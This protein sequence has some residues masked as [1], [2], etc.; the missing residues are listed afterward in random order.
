MGKKYEI[1]MTS[2]PIFSKIL[3]FALPLML[4]SMLQLLF[5]TADVI[6]VGRFCGASSLAA[7]GSTGSLTNL[8]VNLF[9]GFSVGTNVIAAQAV[10]SGDKNLARDTVHT[11]VLFSAICGV[12]LSII[13]VVLCKPLLLMMDT[14]DDVIDKSALYMRIYFLGMPFSMLYNF[15][16]AVLRA[17]GDTKRPMYYLVIA[18]VVNVV[19]NIIFVTVF[20]IDVAGV[21]LATIIAQV[22]SAVLIV[23][24]LMRLD[25]SCKL[26]LKKIRIKKRIMLKILKI[27]IPAGIQSTMF[28]VSNVLIQSS[29]NFFG[30]AVMAGNAAAANIEG[31][32]YVAMEAIRQ[33]SLSF[34]SQNYGAEKM[35]RVK[36]VFI[37][38]VATVAVIGIVLG[39][40]VAHLGGYLLPLYTDELEV[41][42]HGMVRF[43]YVAATYFLCG[44]MDTIIGAIR[45]LGSTVIP[46]ILS[47]VWACG[48]RIVWICTVF[49]LDK[50]IETVYISYPISWLSA[51]ICQFMYFI[52]CFKRIKKQKSLSYF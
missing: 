25:N 3:R 22:I 39:N 27:G 41:I 38:C 24:C 29:V 16:Y 33:T 1:D 45:G 40:L 19:L 2:G 43:S 51:A 23:R 18:G 50:S 30:K 34:T 7:V 44:I 42:Q 12:G 48:F 17:I 47:V 9:I 10:G 4:S 26:Y 37:E 49:P 21:A 35:D 8:L 11:S 28:S 31:F 6:V 15:C 14:P 13:G 52:W 36:K 32:V 46:M 20:H 5:N